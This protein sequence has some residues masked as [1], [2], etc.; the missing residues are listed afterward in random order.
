MKPQNI[1]QTLSLALAIGFFA[2]PAC[3]DTFDF[4][5]STTV[6][7]AGPNGQTLFTSASG[8]LTTTN[9]EVNGAVLITGITGSRTTNF[10]MGQF[11]DPAETDQI[12]GLAVP[13]FPVIQPDNLLY[14]NSSAY[15]DFNGFAY[16]LNCYYCGSY[17]GGFVQAAGFGG[18]YYEL[19]PTALVGGTS[20]FTL[21]PIPEPKPF[22]ILAIAGLVAIVCKARHVAGKRSRF[23]GS[24][25][26]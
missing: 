15:L 3:A 26:G 6:Y 16:K 24:L 20:T 7:S 1:S 11:F 2:L 14:P 9:T 25:P 17:E 4:S 21:T 13:Q 19:G 23:G 18:N 5:Y 8:I 10:Y 22:A 12:V